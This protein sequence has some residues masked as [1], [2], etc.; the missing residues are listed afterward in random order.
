MKKAH[1]F[2][3]IITL[4]SFTTFA[5]ESMSDDR[6]KVKIGIKLG[7]NYS[8]YYDS[9]GEEFS[10][11][12]KLGLAGGLFF[13]IPI[14]KFLGIQ[15]EILYSQ[16]GYKETGQF[17]GGTYKLT[18]TTDYLD[19]P[20][21]LSIKPAKF[22]TIQ[23][24]PQYSYLLKQKDVFENPLTTVEQQNEF[25]NENIRK[26]ILGFIGGLDVNVGKVIIG[27]KAGWDIQNN[28]GDGTSTNPRYKNAWT[29]ATIGF[30]IL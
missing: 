1:I 26:N 11:D 13:G 8:N 22:L 29:Q 5:Q 10:A 20:L 27:A 25:K 28:N 15:P 12:S 4:L 17:L 30:N 23:V 6:G 3:T 16:K 9:K 7:G 18:R 21:L 19:V 2:L 14:G 24:G